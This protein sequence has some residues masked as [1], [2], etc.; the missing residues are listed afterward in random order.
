MGIKQFLIAS[1][2]IFLSINL[3]A[4]DA[5]KVVILKGIV[6]AK[7]SDGTLVDV[8]ENQSIPVG[9]ELQT[10]DKSFVK[11][12]LID[13]SQMNLGPNS[14]M[15]ITSFPKKEAGII[16]LVKGQIRSQV[17]KDYMEI[18]NKEKSKL[19]IKT[20]SAAMGI[21]GTDFQV[22]FNPENQNTA[23][24]TFEGAVAM[25][26]IE[27]NDKGNDFDQK[28][29]ESVVSSPSAVM[30][31]QGQISAVNL[32]V[33]EKPMIPT[34]LAITQVE[35]LKNNET[36][37]KEGN[38][39]NDQK[40]FKSPIPPGIDGA[41]L[42]N[43][44]AEIDKQFSKFAAT[45]PNQD[46]KQFEKGEPTGFFNDKTGD[47][48]LP[49]GSIVDLNTVNIIP[50][51]SNAVFDPNTKTFVVPETFGKIDAVTG[52]YKAPEGMKLTPEGKFIENP[53]KNKSNDLKNN[54]KPNESGKPSGESNGKPG[55]EVVTNP[56]GTNERKPASIETPLMNGPMP[57]SI[58]EVRPEMAQFALKY[59]PVFTSG[60]LPPPP[61]TDQLKALADQKITTTETVKQDATNT[62]TINPNTKVKIN[63]GSN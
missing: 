37:I 33:G 59:A 44:N 63:F 54:N 49:A 19:F 52:E 10:A 7:L 27:R 53:D 14:K 46:V 26:H 60:T 43:N 9:A 5:A 36:G 48:K 55:D 29:L 62:G 11:I 32:N 13:K 61:I 40:S 34:K 57:G 4:E 30:V 1:T 6:K 50:P 51:P 12:I 25:G 42:S 8:K 39:E 58:Y 56:D 21:R 41:V 28:M 35:A 16:T 23:L 31:R 24:I 2:F 22:N 20:N 45:M 47:Y 38:N 3:Y 18:E 17:T 15:I